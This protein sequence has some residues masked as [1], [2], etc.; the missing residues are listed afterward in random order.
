MR[1]IEYKEIVFS[2]FLLWPPIYFCASSILGL[3]IEEGD[4]APG[5]VYGLLILGIL[6]TYYVFLKGFNFIINNVCFTIIIPL[7]MV[8]EFLFESAFNKEPAFQYMSYFLG[9]CIPAI[10]IGVYI[11]NTGGIKNYTKWFDIV[12]ILLTLGLIYALPNIVF[13]SVIS[14]GGASYQ[15]MAYVAG[16]AFTMNLTGLLFGNNYVR[17]KFT[18]YPL[19]KFL[20]YLFLVIQLVCC[21]Y[22]GGRGGFIYL[23]GCSL[24]LLLYKKKYSY[25]LYVVGLLFLLYLVSFMLQGSHF[26]D[27]LSVRMERTFSFIGESGIDKQNRGEVW[28]DAALLFQES[29]GLG[30]GLFSYFNIMRVRY[31]QPYAHNFFLEILIQGGVYY[32]LFWVILLAKFLKKFYRLI[33]RN[34]CESLLIVLFLYPFIELMFSATYLQSTLFW[35]TLS[36]VFS[37]PNKTNCKS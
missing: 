37:I 17:F 26:A 30:I 3:Q 25:L 20:F 29:N 7:F 4:G 11:A 24:M 15:Q 31:N 1:N 12:M 13:L 2:L 35:F 28:N 18:K 19:V 33:T 21:L 32:F 10:F 6:S 34:R 8:M 14:L 9:F 5:Y 27:V 36:Y 23:I 22:S 16:L